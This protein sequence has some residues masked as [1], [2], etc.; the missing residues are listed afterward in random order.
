MCGGDQ[1]A[2][3]SLINRFIVNV[4][5][6]I[7]VW[8]MSGK[9]RMVFALLA[10]ILIG[11]F[12]YSR[13]HPGASDVLYGETDL[14]YKTFMGD[15]KIDGPTTF[16]DIKVEG[17]TTII[18][19]VKDSSDGTF[20]SL[21]IE[22]PADMTTIS[23]RKLTMRGPLTCG[24]CTLDEVNVLGPV[25]LTETNIQN[26][27]V[28]GP[29]G[30]DGIDVK[31]FAQVFGPVNVKNSHFEKLELN[32]TEATFND[33]G[34][35][36]IVVTPDES[37]R[38]QVII[39]TGSTVVES[40]IVFQSGNGEVE[41][42]GNGVKYKGVVGGIFKLDPEAEAAAAI[43]KAEIEAAK[44]SVETAK[45]DAEAAKANAETA[46][47]EARAARSEAAKAARDDVKEAPRGLLAPG[48]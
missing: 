33:T 42:R 37:N 41:V 14:K 18:G 29:L 26:L 6:L 12:V 22:G 10:I 11:Y 5:H 20:A 19:P 16:N 2:C 23:A 36:E 3:K 17:S 30:G 38:Q 15:L 47:A 1:K 32:S 34:I 44:A 25:T 4:C 35:E 13:M 7:M 8:L 45:S 48:N 27:T 43:V 31:V 9:S 21:D 39:L 24:K 40:D 28:T 46:R